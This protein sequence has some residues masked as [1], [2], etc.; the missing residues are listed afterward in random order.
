MPGLTYDHGLTL[1]FVLA[2]SIAR[3]SLFCVPKGPCINERFVQIP[4]LG[5]VGYVEGIWRPF[6]SQ[7]LSKGRDFEVTMHVVWL[8]PCLPSRRDDGFVG[9]NSGFSRLRIKGMYFN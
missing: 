2:G 4:I 6:Y 1:P 5:S 3:A 7:L 9:L 8:R